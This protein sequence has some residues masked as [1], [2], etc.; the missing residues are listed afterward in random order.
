MPATQLHVAYPA[1]DALADFYGY[2]GLHA[3]ANGEQA[4]EVLLAE[5]PDAAGDLRPLHEHLE[6]SEL[7][8]TFR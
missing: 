3:P 6:Q 7:S 8:V 1:I 4:L 2:P 5:C